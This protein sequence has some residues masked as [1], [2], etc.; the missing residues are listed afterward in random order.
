MLSLISLLTAIAERWHKALAAIDSE[1]QLLET[2]GQK[3]AF[4]L[5]DADPNLV[6]LHTGTPDCPMAFTIDLEPKEWRKLSKRAIK[7][8]VFGGSTNPNPLV[9]LLDRMEERQHRWH[10]AGNVEAEKMFG[11]GCGK[12]NE[13]VEGRDAHCVR[14]ITQVRRMVGSLDWS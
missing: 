1:T 9:A 14:L 12:Q 5:G 3:K 8:E 4:R 2:T 13:P 7:S 10:R 6:H 11:P